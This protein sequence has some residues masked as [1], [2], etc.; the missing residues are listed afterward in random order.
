LIFVA[1]VEQ[2]YYL[3][4][5]LGMVDVLVPANHLGKGHL[6]HSDHA[7][8]AGVGHIGALQVMVK[9]GKPRSVSE[10]GRVLEQF[11]EQLVL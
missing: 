7:S 8:P 11:E 9:L 10:P 5:L 3:Q 1:V 4:H 6:T 2:V